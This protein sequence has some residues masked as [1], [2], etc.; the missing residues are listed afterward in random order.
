MLV[1]RHTVCTP[2]K[3]LFVSVSCLAVMILAQLTLFDDSL[4]C[5]NNTVVIYVLHEKK[6]TRKEANKQNCY[7]KKVVFILEENQQLSSF[8]SNLC[9]KTQKKTLK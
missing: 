8:L 3:R 6:K 2:G 1:Q 9:K 5:H 7:T 4:I